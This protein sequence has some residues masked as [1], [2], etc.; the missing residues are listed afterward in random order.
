VT[1][2]KKRVT[3]HAPRVEPVSIRELPE[4]SHRVAVLV[5]LGL[6]LL[7]FGDVLF[8]PGSR[9][10]SQAGTDLAGQF[11]GWRDFG[12]RELSQGHLPLWNPYVYSGSPYF[13][14]FQS[15]LLYPLN[16]PY[17]FLPLARAV[18]VGIAL[19]VFLG[20]LFMYCWVVGRRLHRTAGLLAAILFMFCGAHFSHIYAGH[21]PNLC[22]MAWAPLLFLAI[23]RVI[24]RCSVGWC[25][26]GMAVVAMQLLAGHPQYA[27]YTAI[28]AGLYALLNL[29]HAERRMRAL[30]LLGAVYA[31]ALLLSSVQL[32]P[33]LQASG[34]SIRS[35]SVSYEYAAGFSFPPEN[36]LTLLTPYAWGGMTTYL[37]RD[38]LFEM[39]LFLGLAGAVLAL[40]GLLRGDRLQRR[41]SGIMVGLLAVLAL[42]AYTP[43]FPVLYRHVPGFDQLRGNSKFIFQMSLFLIMLAAVGADHLLRRRA[44]PRFTATGLAAGGFALAAA[45]LAVWQSSAAGPAGWWGQVIEGLAAAGESYLP[46]DFS[47]NPAYVQHAGTVAAQGLLV[48]AVAALV[49]AGLFRTS[50]KAAWATY[51]ILGV[52][53]VEV[54]GYAALM[55]PTFDAD[56]FCPRDLVSMTREMAGSDERMLNLIVPNG[57]ALL[58]TPDVWGN[59]PTVSRR[60]AE[61]LAY[62]E[63]ESPAQ[64]TQYVEFRQPHR[65]FGLVRCR[66][67]FFAEGESVRRVDL[68]TLLP[69]YHPLP[70]LSLIEE[71]EVMPGRDAV[72]G[73]MSAATFDSRRTVILESPPDPAPTG[74]RAAGSARV[75]DSSTD[76]LTITADL[77]EPA[78][79]LVSDA[80]ATGWTATPLPGSVQTRYTVMPADYVLRA[81]PMAKG[82]HRLRLEYRPRGFTIGRR[83]SLVALTLYLVGIAAFFA[84]APL[85]AGPHGSARFATF[86]T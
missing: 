30:L 71:Y 9:V 59:D 79:L 14:G 48:A 21:L 81:I 33:G 51:A 52:G 53:A 1:R 63:G 24:E 84:T 41:F 67:L 5:L 45:S 37:G 62:T 8:L 83:V 29:I 55:R 32:L 77:T 10:L 76:H 16:A 44:V 34:E 35:G 42:G 2:N 82:H 56:Q 11:L 74:T 72:L 60:Y 47:A 78:I 46:P 27:F 13:G 38:Y 58:R 57:G 61:F 6:T 66:Y 15:A 49:L 85:S 36:A 39:N 23:D 12:F 4:V 3:P 64:A 40:I 70:R 68:E 17:L 75:L 80:Y 50:V 20:G 65:L 22:T 86:R 31:G 28:A 7:M 19:H 26:A 43:L 69:D 73:A 18:N 54:F 25:L